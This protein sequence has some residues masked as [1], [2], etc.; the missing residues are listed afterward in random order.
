METT[1]GNH[2]ANAIIGTIEEDWR[3]KI[4]L[5]N[6][7]ALEK[8]NHF[9]V[10]KF[11]DES[12]SIFW[13]DGIKQNDVLLFL[14]DSA[15]YLIECGKLLNVLYSKMVYVECTVR[16][17]H[18]TSDEVS[19]QFGIIDKIVSNVKTFF[20]KRFHIYKYLSCILRTFPYHTLE[21]VFSR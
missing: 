15:P 18:R 6:T 7:N 21:P 19:G 13:F 8:T 10:C 11:F 4:F 16:V 3:S 14:L 20:L 1:K 5:L 12:L 2:A 9:N 17:L